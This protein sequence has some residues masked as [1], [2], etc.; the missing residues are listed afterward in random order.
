MQQQRGSGK[1]AVLV[2]RIIEKV[3]NDKI[4]IDKILVVTFTNAAASEMRDRILDAIYMKIEEDPE[5]YHLQRQLTL[6]NNAS[7]CTIHAF[8]LE[9]IRNY[10]YEIDISNNFRI[11]DTAEI[12]LIKTEVITE[13]F[14]KK[15]E[16]QDSGFLKLIE[17]YTGYRSDEDLIELVLDI[18]NY[19]QS[20]PFPKKWIEEKV[21]MLKIDDTIT[22]FAKTPWGQIIIDET[23][24]NINECILKLMKIKSETS[25]FIELEKFTNVLEEDI[26]RLTFII[27][28][29]NSWDSLYENL[30]YLEWEK[31]PID[32]KVTI[33]LKDDAKAIR[34]K[35]RKELSSIKIINNSKEAKNDINYMH[36]IIKELQ[37]LV[38]EFSSDFVN[39]KK[40]KNIVDF[41]DIEHF[42]L[43][44]L[45]KEE[46]GII[47]KTQVAEEYVKKY[48]EILID[49]YQDSNLVQEY[50]LNSISK[51]NNI[52]MV[53]DVKQSIYKFR[54]AKPEL[55]LEK[56]EKYKLK[57]MKTKEDDLKIQL[58][59][60]FRSRENVLDLTNLIFENIM[61]KKLGE[62]EYTKEEFLYYGANYEE[63]RESSLGI[64]ELD[65]ID[66]KENEENDIYIKTSEEEEKE[67]K[68]EEENI[69]NNVLEAKFVA[70]KIK[71]LINSNY[72][73]LDK[74]EGYRKLK[75]K[76][77]C[78]LLRATAN[79]A[80]IYEKEIF[81]LGIPVFS[82]TSSTY[83]DSME[84]QTIMSL[85]KVIDNPMQDIPLVTVMRSNI[86]KFTDNELIK[87]RLADRNSCF[88][89][90]LLKSRL[91]LEGELKEKV[92]VLLNNL[93]KW[94]KKEKYMPI[95]EFIWEIYLDTG[96][97]HYVGLLNNGS[98]RQANLKLLFEKAKQY[99]NVS[100]KGLFNFI[101]FIDKVRV[102]TN[103]LGAAKLISEN[104]NVVRIMSIHK[105][106]GLEFPIVFLSNTGKKFNFQDLNKQVLLHQELGIGPK[107]IDFERKIE[108]D[109][110]AKEAIKIK[111]KRETISEEMRILYVALTRAREKLIITGF[112]KDLQKSFEEKEQNL[113]LYENQEN[114]KIDSELVKKYNSYLDWLE[115]IYIYNKDKLKNIIDL[116]EYKK[117]ELINKLSKEDDDNIN[118]EKILNENLKNKELDGELENKLKWKYKYKISEQIPTKT[119]VTKLKVQ[120]EAE[121]IE[122]L[123]NNKSLENVSINNV[124]KF[125]EN[126]KELTPMQKGTLMHLCVQKLDEKEKYNS[127]KDIQRFIQKLYENSIITEIELKSVNIK[128]LLNYI[129]SD[130]FKELK[131]AKEVHKEEPF[132]INIKANDLYKDAEANENILVQG[133]IDLYFIDKDD[134]LILVDFK[135][136]YIKK[137]EEYKLEEKYKIQLDLYK[138]ALEESLG[139]K[140]DKAMIYSLS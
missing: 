72:M 110:L 111:I 17:T 102:S 31:W 52:F 92:E 127:L 9:I 129:K 122:D 13:I 22:D 126:K 18:Y 93:G 64:A 139:R 98:L 51:G 53:G 62:V 105:S 25:K 100:F 26:N 61:S 112:S 8:C 74:K 113:K 5:N 114:N 24:R 12:E 115:L 76:D 46:N 99:E 133:I 119:S 45:L 50:I 3:L 80:E 23:K 41:N 131:T 6:I 118:I 91:I 108:F 121:N 67:D 49:E 65:I 96:F 35:V 140:V 32:R 130:L 14:E 10:F 47:K 58:F 70:N 124:P 84:I 116:K 94:R 106:K 128:A 135:T 85:L 38:L 7:I 136:D 79:V 15:Y 104:E 82:D 87:I 101:N 123:L 4:D 107:F 132:Y 109:T 55:F 97:Y 34:D 57:N 30:N 1:T 75:Y 40:E 86:G 54:Q 11:A 56:Y 138:K 95:D 89:E 63:N 33:T 88:Y 117:K 2:E 60:N 27:K 20:N 77:I 83:L 66:L 90:A 28:N 43:K 16:S 81:D 21:N 69:E 125:I 134:K 37:N 103:D 44:I 71:E 19:I 73:V 137:G 36:D 29:S 120:K 39:V 59:K 68:D 42:A 78:I 48:E